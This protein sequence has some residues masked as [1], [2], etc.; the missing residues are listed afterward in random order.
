MRKKTL[1]TANESVVSASGNTPHMHS[2]VNP[3]CH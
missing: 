1:Q 3:T 2:L